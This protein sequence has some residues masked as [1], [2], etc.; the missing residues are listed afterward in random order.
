MLMLQRKSAVI[1]Q[2]L[3]QIICTKPI[4]LQQNTKSYK[5]V[6]NKLY[7]EDFTS[8]QQFLRIGTNTSLLDQ[9]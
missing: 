6:K 1:Q 3:G 7:E 8:F 2:C 4:Q 9:L 5:R